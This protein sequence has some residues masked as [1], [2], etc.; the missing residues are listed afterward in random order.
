MDEEDVDFETLLADKRHKELLTA[1]KGILTSVDQKK[2]SEVGNAIK[3]QELVINKFIEEVSR[4]SQRPI[5]LNNK[6]VVTSIKTMEE[7]VLKIGVTILEELKA[8][9]EQLA[10]PRETEFKYKRNFG[11]YLDTV[12]A[13]EIK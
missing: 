7:N 2:D 12:V 3:R 10:R 13:K 9:K 4:I 6:E 11:G 8:L 1:L 5:S